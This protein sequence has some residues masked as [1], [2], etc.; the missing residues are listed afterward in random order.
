MNTCYISLGSN[1]ENPLSQVNCALQAIAELGEITLQSSWYESAAIGPGD[2]PSY[3]N[4]VI[5]LET[6]LSPPEL[7]SALQ[8]IENQQGRKRIVR[9][10]A[11]TLDLDILLFNS[12]TL[13]NEKLTIPHPCMQE[14]N[15]VIYPLHEIAPDLQLP[16]GE[17]I[18]D[19]KSTLLPQGLEKLRQKG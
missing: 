4:G 11:R 6:H 13:H 14:R 3:I 19:I 18:A 5:A 8:A 2:Q 15:F 10:G 1:L 17:F 7:L 12:I 9:W 16:D